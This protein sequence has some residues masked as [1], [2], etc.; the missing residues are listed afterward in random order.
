ME[1]EE[2]WREEGRCA[3]KTEREIEKG[4]EACDSYKKKQKKSPR[5]LRS[6]E[7]NHKP[8]K[9]RK[10]DLKVCVGSR[11]PAADHTETRRTETPADY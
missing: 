5:P 11:K 1:E 6:A 10:K 4:K 2:R 7:Q 8:K 3:G 9:D